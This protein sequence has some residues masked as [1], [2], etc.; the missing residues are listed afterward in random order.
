MLCSRLV[1][2]SITRSAVFAL[3]FIQALSTVDQ[4]H[5][6]TKRIFQEW[7]SQSISITTARL[8]A[9]GWM[10][11]DKYML[12]MFLFW[13]AKW[14]CVV[15]GFHGAFA[16]FV[17]TCQ[18]I[19]LPFIETLRSH[20]VSRP[21]PHQSICDA[22]AGLLPKTYNTITSTTAWTLPFG[23]YLQCLTLKIHHG[24]IHSAW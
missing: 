8:W 11:T 3:A 9:L 20:H 4:R 17:S 12:F 1:K 18:V 13:Q 7:S 23:S 15:W 10:S 21:T 22:A 2:G 16:K 6:F 5:P 19:N 24:R 14:V